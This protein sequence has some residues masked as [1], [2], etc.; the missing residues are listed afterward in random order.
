MR[1]EVER[2]C[3]EIGGDPLL[4]QGA[5]GNA[6]WKDGNTLWVKASGT[7]LAEAGQRDIFVPVDL[8]HLNAAIHAGDFAVT[9]RA[10][11]VSSLRPS[12]ETLLHALMPHPFVIHLHAVEVLTHLVRAQFPDNVQSLLGDGAPRWAGVAYCKP[13]ADLARAIAEQLSRHTG[14]DII[15]MQ[16]HGVVIGG[17]DVEQVRGVLA[18]LTEKLRTAPRVQIATQPRALPALLA[19]AYEPISD[20]AIHQLVIDQVLFDR[21]ERD[22]ALYPDHVVFLGA[23]PACFDN[24]ERFLSAHPDPDAWPELLFLRGVGVHAR[25]GL[26]LAKLVQLRCYYDVLARQPAEQA[27]H[28]LSPD[29]IA[30]LLNWDAEKY[31]MALS[32]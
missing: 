26:T 2:F 3:A 32:R 1:A 4:A 9:P 10:K 24:V 22:W 28:S 6:S 11:G 15:M 25:R 7:W 13:G 23:R 16:S 8:D 5:G 14:A 12:I 29:Q 20:D 31:R 21:L 17:R 19:D 27:L 30:S 18:Q